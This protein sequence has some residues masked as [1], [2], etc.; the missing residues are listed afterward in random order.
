M[1]AFEKVIYWIGIYSICA[2]T[3]DY[4]EEV[5]NG[6]GRRLH[7]WSKNEHPE[8]KKPNRGV[9]LSTGETGEPINRIGF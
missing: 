6:L 8:K 3:S 5:L 7:D 1:K 9:N 2:T 4:L